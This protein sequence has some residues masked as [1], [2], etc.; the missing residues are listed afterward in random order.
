[1]ENPHPKRTD[2]QHLV[3]SIFD[4]IRSLYKLSALLRR[5]SVPNKYI[6]SICKDQVVSHFGNW[7]QAHVENKFRDAAAHLVQR[8][9]LANTRRR[10]QLRYWENHP[11]R[12]GTDQPQPTLADHRSSQLPLEPR[13]SSLT[14]P[15]PHRMTMK[16]AA[17]MKPSQS[18][19]V[20]S[21][22]TK[23]SFSTVAL[24]MLN[25][26][27]AS[28]NH[29]RTVYESSIQGATRSLRVPDVPKASGVTSTFNCPF[30]FARLDVQTMQK[31]HLWK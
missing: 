11:E 13:P 29:S 15:W 14:G 18:L 25:D 21:Q 22:T 16:P 19:G 9:G 2:F 23:Q 1:M 4:H 26:A 31:R 5:P 20:T 8:L 27:E 24:S 6:R 3:A 30:C 10:Q 12:Y 7:D 28:C 17:F